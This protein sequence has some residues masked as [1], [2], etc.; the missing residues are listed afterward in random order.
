MP[1]YQVRTKSQNPPT[2]LIAKQL[3]DVRQLFELEERPCLRDLVRGLQVSEASG[4]L[5][6]KRP[7]LAGEVPPESSPM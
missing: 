5:H 6:A 1:T 2:L 3:I 7:W 4:F